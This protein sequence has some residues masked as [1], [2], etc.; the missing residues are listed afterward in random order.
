[1]DK[2][3]LHGWYGLYIYTHYM[4]NPKKPPVLKRNIIFQRPSFSGS[5]FGLTAGCI[6]SIAFRTWMMVQKVHGTGI[7][8]PG[9]FHQNIADLFFF[10]FG[11]DDLIIWGR[12]FVIMAWLLLGDFFV[13]FGGIFFFWGGGWWLLYIFVIENHDLLHW[14][15]NQPI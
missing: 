12:T 7:P 11:D 5:M 8:I 3:A 13:W 10:L 2:S 15:K 4:I 14:K 1:M 9:F 6:M